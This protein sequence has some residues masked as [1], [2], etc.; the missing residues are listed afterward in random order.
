MNNNV[1][2]IAEAGV[3]HNGSL[4]LAFKLCDA[5]K[6]AGADAVK[7]QI[8]NPAKLVCKGTEKADYQKENDKSS[9]NQFDMLSKLALSE[10]DFLQIS[11]YCK[12]IDISFMATAFDEDS[13]MFLKNLGT[14]VIKVPSGE[15]TNLP[16]LRKISELWNQIIMSTGMCS[17]DEIIDAYNILCHNGANVT[18]LHCTTEYPAPFETINL[19]YMNTIGN[20][21][22]VN[23]GYSDHTKGIEVPIAA[24]ALGASVIE[25]HFTLDK[26]MDGPDHKAS[27]NPEELSNMVSAIRNI[28]KALGNGN[29]VVNNIEESNKKVIRKSI[30]AAC[31]IKK[32]DIFTEQN[33]TCKRPGTGISPMLW[34]EVIGKQATRNYDEDEMIEL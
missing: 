3:N 11:E 14:N 26:S 2:I 27:L 16:Y 7:F 8:F 6:R 33:L 25:K 23:Y 9:D 28:E 29:K 24:V 34:D 20:K 21:L 15:I 17:E 22:K 18:V 32:G 13:L 30:V 19:K 5:A 4:D 10:N 31:H 12:K 1:F